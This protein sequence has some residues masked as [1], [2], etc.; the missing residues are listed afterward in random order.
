[1]EVHITYGIILNFVYEKVKVSYVV[2]HKTSYF[3]Y[4]LYNVWFA[5]F[6][7]VSTDQ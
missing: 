4:Y 3:L 7:Y 5:I 6:A 2:W 1:M